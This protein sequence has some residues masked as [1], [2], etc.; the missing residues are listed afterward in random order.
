MVSYDFTL[1][2]KIIYLENRHFFFIKSHHMWTISSCISSPNKVSFNWFSLKSHACLTHSPHSFGQAC[3]EFLPGSVGQGTSLDTAHWGCTEWIQHTDA[4]SAG[5]EV[6]ANLVW[7]PLSN[8]MAKSFL[9]SAKGPPRDWQCSLSRLHVAIHLVTLGKSCPCLAFRIPCLTWETLEDHLM[10]WQAVNL[11]KAMDG[12]APHPKHYQVS[13]K[14]SIT[15]GTWDWVIIGKWSG[16]VEAEAG[17]WTELRSWWGLSVC[18]GESRLSIPY[19]TKT[20]K[21]K[22][23]LRQVT[24]QLFYYFIFFFAS[25]PPSVKQAGWFLSLHCWFLSFIVVEMTK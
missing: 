12:P 19:W 11:E 1:K 25:F 24:D 9:Y 3:S 5:L 21:A 14:L 20:F 10:I 17:P 15:K 23:I 7:N 8:H 13:H 18:L 6:D 2:N 16:R 22:S 4:I